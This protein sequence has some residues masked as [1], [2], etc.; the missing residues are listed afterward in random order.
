MSNSRRT[1]VLIAEQKEGSVIENGAIL[2]HTA[3]F[4]LIVILRRSLGV[5]FCFRV[6][7]R[8]QR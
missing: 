3:F 6:S 4:L 2:Y 5:Y 8:A 1:N 7:P